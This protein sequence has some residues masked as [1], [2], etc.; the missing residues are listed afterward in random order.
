MADE[1]KE[2]RDVREAWEVLHETPPG[3]LRQEAAERALESAIEARTL[4]KLRAGVAPQTMTAAQERV[5]RAYGTIS[6]NAAAAEIDATRAALAAVRETIETMQ[7]HAQD[8]VQQVQQERESAKIVNAAA[9][10]ALKDNEVLRAKLEEVRPYV[11]KG[12]A[13]P[14]GPAR[15][16]RARRAL[17][18]E[19]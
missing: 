9:L 16:E 15:L 12:V 19:S 6:S 1:S 2:E 14:D 8:L 3:R 4:A 17:G 13:G 10:E 18:I 5:L 7:R 11:E